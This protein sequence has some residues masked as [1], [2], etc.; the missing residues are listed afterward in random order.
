MKYEYIVYKTTNTVNKKIYIGVHKS[1]M[2]INDGYLGCGIYK[3]SVKKMK[4]T[5]IQAAFKK[6]GFNKFIRETLFTFPDTEEGKIQ[7]YKKEAELVNRDFIKRKDVYNLCLGG[8]VPSSI[9]ER[10][11]AQYDLNGKFIKTYYSIKHAA[12]LTG[13]SKSGIQAACSSESY[14]GEYQWRYFNGDKSNITEANTIYKTVYQFDLQGNYIT[15]YKSIVEAA[16]KNNLKPNDISAVCRKK[17]GQA[18]GYF[19]N[20]KKSFD[21]DPEHSDKDIAVACYDDNGNFIKSYTSLRSAAED[22]KINRGTIKRC[23]SGK[24]KHAGKFRWRY[25]YGN[26]S[27]ISPL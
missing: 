9:R 22:S 20:F 27:N 6:Y 5:G 4:K 11:I 12:D 1:P 25:F 17:Q 23:I 7:A 26:T 21:F 15:Y 2:G 10:E 8:K 19:W 16:K 3:D 18:G 24:T 14:C 13:I